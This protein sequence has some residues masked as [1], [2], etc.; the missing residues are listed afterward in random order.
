MKEIT[1][2]Y[3]GHCPLCRSEMMQIASADKNKQVDFVNLHSARFYDFESPSFDAAM[4]ELHVIIDG[5]VY[6]G[7][8]AN[9]LLWRRLGLKPWLS[10]LDWPVIRL[11][12]Q[13][14]Y[15]LFAKYR[16]TISRLVTGQSRCTNECDISSE[17]RV[18]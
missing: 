2:F 13:I 3:D 12:T 10:V 9:I 7:A 4:Y 8:K 11:F 5:Q 18:K 17:F 16:Y 6:R 1:V 15:R 14:A